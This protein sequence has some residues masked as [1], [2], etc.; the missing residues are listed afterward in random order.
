M[1]PQTGSSGSP[2]RIAKPPRLAV[3][4]FILGC[5][6][7]FLPPYSCPLPQTPAFSPFPSRGGSV[8]YHV[9]MRD[10]DEVSGLID[11]QLESL[12]RELT[13]VPPRSSIGLGRFAE[14]SGLCALFGRPDLA[15]RLADVLSDAPAV[16]LFKHAIT[17]IDPATVNVDAF[18]RPRSAVEVERAHPPCSHEALIGQLRT[19]AE[20]D[21]ASEEPRHHLALCLTGDVDGAMRAARGELALEEVAATLVVLGQPERATAL[22]DAQ[23]VSDYRRQ[24]IRFVILAEACRRRLLG[25]APAVRATESR[26][27]SRV[28][29]ILALAGRL[30][31]AGYPFSDW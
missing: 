14:A 20:G 29:V 28:P 18:R 30:P 11:E 6:N 24:A 5:A 25:F 3:E 10:D 15:A 12:V 7:Q 13:A 19:Q 1:K 8:G 16:D 26:G 31:W 4:R 2:T 23:P 27:H 21:A 9:D 22:I 17:N